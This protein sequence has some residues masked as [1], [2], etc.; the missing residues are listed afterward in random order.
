MANKKT[1]ICF[2]TKPT[3]R[4]FC[5]FVCQTQSNIVCTYLSAVFLLV[6]SLRYASHFLAGFRRNPAVSNAIN[7]HLVKTSFSF[8]EEYQGLVEKNFPWMPYPYYWPS[9]SELDV[10]SLHYV[11]INIF[12]SEGSQRKKRK[13]DIPVYG[14]GGGLDSD[15]E[16][17]STIM[18][19]WM[20]DFHN[21]SIEV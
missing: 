5:I 14:R 20:R 10:I 15:F 11:A 13:K 12:V 9:G 6:V 21:P 8:G 3:V 7:L 19:L 18:W 4:W 2:V 1:R 17:F 16:S